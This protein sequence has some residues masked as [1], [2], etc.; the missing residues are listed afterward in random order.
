MNEWTHFSFLF[1]LHFPPSSSMPL[2][3]FCIKVHRWDNNLCW[4]DLSLAWGEKD[5][6][7]F[8]YLGMKYVLPKRTQEDFGLTI[9]GLFQSG[10]F[11]YG[12]WIALCVERGKKGGKLANVNHFHYLT[13]LH[14]KN[15]FFHNE[16]LEWI[17]NLKIKSDSPQ[18]LLYHLI[19][20]HSHRNES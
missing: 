12:Q 14:F 17:K 11:D 19:T 4:G 13:L 3:T 15:Y 1:F 16:I 2:P 9:S 7:R 6:H 5:H 8:D 18:D 20:A 10:L